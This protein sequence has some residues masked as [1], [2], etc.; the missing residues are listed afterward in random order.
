M[1]GIYNAIMK[2]LSTEIIHK[3]NANTQTHNHMDNPCAQIKYNRLKTQALAQT[4]VMIS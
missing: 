1:L 2:M 4:L 3:Q